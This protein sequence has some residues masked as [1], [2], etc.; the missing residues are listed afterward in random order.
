MFGI[1]PWG[2]CEAD[3]PLLVKGPQFRDLGCQVHSHSELLHQ[4]KVFTAPSTEF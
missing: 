3:K 4:P 1:D 2:F